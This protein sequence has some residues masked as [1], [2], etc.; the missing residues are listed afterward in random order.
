MKPLLLCFL[1]IIA[2]SS[3]ASAAPAGSKFCAAAAEWA[4]AEMGLHI[5][6]PAR[7]FENAVSAFGA[8]QQ[9]QMEYFSFLAETIYNEKIHPSVEGL[10]SMTEELHKLHKDFARDL[11]IAT[12]KSEFE[13]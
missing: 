8:L 4:E 3:V 10:E 11:A 7:T 5:D 13:Q 1:T 6:N 12:C 9:A 2:S